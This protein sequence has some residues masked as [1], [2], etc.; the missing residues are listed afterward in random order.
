VR[1]RK[2]QTQCSRRGLRAGL[3]VP[4]RLNR[5][6]SLSVCEPH[7]CSTAL[8]ASLCSLSKD[9]RWHEAH[10]DR[11][12]HNRIGWR[13]RDGTRDEFLIPPE[14]WR[15]EVCAPVG[16]DPTATARTLDARGFLRRGEGKNLSVKE[17]LPGCP[18][19]MRVYAVKA[20]LLEAP[21]DDA[22][23]GNS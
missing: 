9:G 21:A 5:R 6:R 8:A 7:W 2:R 12:V 11:P 17:R 3:V 4:V 1:P 16:L 23:T 14:T 13:K 19:P 18:S 22:E 15:A 20:D 10:P